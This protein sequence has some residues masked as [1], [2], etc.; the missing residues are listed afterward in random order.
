MPHVFTVDEEKWKEA[1]KRSE[2]FWSSE[3]GRKLK[4]HMH[5]C[6]ASFDELIRTGKTT[7]RVI[8]KEGDNES[9]SHTRKIHLVL[10]LDETGYVQDDIDTIQRDLQ[11]EIS[12]CYHSF[13][14]LECF[15]EK[16]NE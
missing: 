9:S 14:I 2:E 6:A 4:Q 13:E 7:V 10:S 15:E 12:C 1:Q 3:E 16:E 11:S 8:Q 5:A